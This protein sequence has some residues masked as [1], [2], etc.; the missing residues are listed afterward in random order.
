MAKKFQFQ[1]NFFILY[2]ESTDAQLID[3]LS[4]SYSGVTCII[5]YFGCF[6]C[7]SI[8][9]SVAWFYI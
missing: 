1:T 7:W 5:C 4:H 9:A 8:L 2:N 6:W 3:K